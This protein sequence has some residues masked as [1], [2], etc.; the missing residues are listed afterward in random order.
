MN[1]NLN[2]FMEFMSSEKGA[3][4]LSSIILIIVLIFIRYLILKVITKTNPKMS[5][6][7]K[8]RW[9]VNL[10]N[11]VV[12]CSIFGLILIW[13]QELQNFAFSIVAFAAA[14]VLATKELIMCVS[15]GLVRATNKSY[16]L[17]DFIEIGCGLTGDPQGV[18]IQI[19]EIAVVR[20]ESEASWKLGVIRWVMLNG[21]GQNINCGLEFLTD[22][23]QAVEVRPVIGSGNAYFTPA[24]QLPANPKQGK[25]S[26]LVL[27]GRVF[28]RLR[29]FIVRYQDGTERAVR[30][31]RLS[32]QTSFYQ[33]AEFLD[34][35]D[36]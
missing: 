33:F 32:S 18:S 25:G 27:T 30:L 35:E 1:D 6:E 17:G 4:L 9:S 26:V 28:S 36:L 20:S 31:S 24:L 34:S 2:T 12:F 14:L 21:N 7:D 16:S 8:R 22:D 10:R 5:M 23:A 3:S 11:I 19:G 15:G 13:A 29:E